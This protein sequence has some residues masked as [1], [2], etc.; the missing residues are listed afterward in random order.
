MINANLFF[1]ILWNFIICEFINLWM[2]KK[3]LSWILLVCQQ[4][5]SFT[6]ALASGTGFARG[7]IYYSAGT[8]ENYFDIT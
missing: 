1:V 8:E 7:I 5:A 2:E 3:I 4:S 6:S